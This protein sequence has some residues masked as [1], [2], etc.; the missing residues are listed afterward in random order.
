MKEPQFPQHIIELERRLNLEKTVFRLIEK[1]KRMQKA[2]LSQDI[3]RKAYKILCDDMCAI[4]GMSQIERD[5]AWQGSVQKSVLD[6]LNR[7]VSLDGVYLPRM[8][9]GD[10]IVD[11]SVVA[12]AAV[13]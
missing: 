9:N 8:K 1:N 4:S 13:V 2:A 12:K 10:V 6:F 7:G 11:P 3:L 5:S